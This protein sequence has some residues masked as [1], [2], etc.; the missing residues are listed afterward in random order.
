VNEFVEECRSEWKRLGVPDPVASEMAAELS[1]DLEEAEAEGVSA[2]EVLGH[3]A[4][5]PRSFATSWA[6]ERGVVHRKL[7]N[8]HGFPRRSL[9]AAAIGVFALIAVI[10]GALVIVASQSSPTRLALTAPDGRQ[11]LVDPAQ[12]D[13]WVPPPPLV[14]VQRI[15]PR[16]LPASAPL[17]LLAD[18]SQIVVADSN[19]SGMDTRTV[20]WVLLT[21]GLAGVVPLTMFGLWFGLGGPYGRGSSPPPSVQSAR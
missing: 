17:A 14:A 9:M 2:E 3:G 19:D 16:S 13:V 7:L 1:A 20:G 8:G 12:A 5:D 4:F 15:E 21:V 6:F 10:G 18:R 11:V